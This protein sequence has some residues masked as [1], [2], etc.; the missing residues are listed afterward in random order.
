MGMRVCHSHFLL[1]SPLLVFFCFLH[2]HFHFHFCQVMAIFDGETL[3]IS[4]SDPTGTASAQGQ[5][6][7]SI[8]IV[9]D[10]TPF[11]SEAG[12]QVADVGRIT[13]AITTAVGE[14]EVTAIVEIADVRM[15]GGFALHMG[16]LVSGR[17]GCVRRLTYQR[18]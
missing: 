2:F 3:A 12:G 11:Y 10:S 5:E 13:T 9:L 16:R 8:G 18:R 15:F 14:E 17:Y 6:Q 4:P 1:I 7:P